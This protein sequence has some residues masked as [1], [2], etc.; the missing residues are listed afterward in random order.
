[1]RA[2]TFLAVVVLVAA[3]FGVP[4]TAFADSCDSYRMGSFIETTC[5]GNGYRVTGSTYTYGGSGF[6]DTT[7]TG[8]S[9]GRSFSGTASTYTYGN[10]FSDTSYTVRSNGSSASGSF[11]C[12]R[13][14]SSRASSSPSS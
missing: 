2:L 12:Y 4:T 6:S 7:F 11:S 14:A 1:M 9:N 3:G 8:T 13:P 10:G 5:S